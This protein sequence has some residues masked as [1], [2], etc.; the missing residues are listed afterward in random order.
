MSKN[1][2][3][4]K[5]EL[6]PLTFFLV[7]EHWCSRMTYDFS[8]GLIMLERVLLVK[9]KVVLSFFLNTELFLV[10]E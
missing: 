2:L 10:F 7:C 1:E 8:D 6:P 3:L 9:I 5:M 4:C